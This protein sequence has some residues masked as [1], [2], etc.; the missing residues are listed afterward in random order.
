MTVIERL[1][2]R[3]ETLYNQRAAAMRQNNFYWLEMTQKKINE[4]EQELIEA[5]KYAPK[6]LSEFLQEQGEDVRDRVY[7]ALIKISLA[8]DFLNDCAFEAKCELDDIGLVEHS[9]TPMVKQACEISQN[10]AS[11]VLTANNEQLTQ[12]ITDNAD[13]IKVCSDAA[14]EHLQKTLNI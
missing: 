1:E 13:F 5:R 4:V 6:K 12:M 14:D 8:A 10:I 9:I 11:F 3:L 2:N 7:K